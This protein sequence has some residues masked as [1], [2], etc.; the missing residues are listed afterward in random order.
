V[1]EA[2]AESGADVLSLDWRVDLADAARRVG[3]RVSLQGN[4]DPCALSAPPAEIARRVR[5][6]AAAGRAARGHVL[7]LGHGVLPE[8]PVE[9]VRAFT[10]AAR[11]LGSAT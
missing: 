1:V 10:A 4:L 11:A 3:S 8:T 5:A 6:L 7:N 9:G 2:M